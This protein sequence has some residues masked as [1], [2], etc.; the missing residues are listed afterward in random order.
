[1]PLYRAGSSSSGGG[2]VA[3]HAHGNI[4]N[5][6][7]IS[8]PF[9]GILSATNVDALSN[10]TFPLFQGGASGGVITVL[11]GVISVTS[12]GTGYVNTVDTSTYASTGGG[13]RFVL[14]TQSTQN[15]PANLPVITTTGGAITAGSFGTT[16]GSHCQG[17]DVRLD[18]FF[19]VVQE[20]LDLGRTPTS[21]PNGWSQ[22]VTV[23]TNI[24]ALAASAPY[25]LDSI[26]WQFT[27]RLGTGQLFSSVS[28]TPSIRIGSQNLLGTLTPVNGVSSY[29]IDNIG[30][31][32]N[33]G[34]RP[35]VGNTQ[36]IQLTTSAGSY[37]KSAYSGGELWINSGTAT[38]N[39]QAL[40]L[41]A[42]MDATQNTFT[43]G[44]YSS[45]N[46][47]EGTYFRIDNEVVLITSWG[48]GN[49]TSPQVLRG[50][51]G[52]TPAPHLSGAVATANIGVENGGGIRANI[53]L[54][55][56]RLY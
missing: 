40:T 48:T 19:T 10:G 32:V 51:L 44:A 8:V 3:S 7:A 55:F 39:Y 28:F 37:G 34:S 6:G 49:G 50:Q 52:T 9:G 54:T 18:R 42:N 2:G 25:V 29:N 11:N 24:A 27:N 13:S 1:M 14:V 17:N 16:A 36:R 23:P 26:A 4:K 56:A 33:I 31:S 35:W 22:Q 30:S 53:Y 15:A 46:S 21:N 5:N 45:A 38:V 47:F 12:A 20:N 43:Q 41:T